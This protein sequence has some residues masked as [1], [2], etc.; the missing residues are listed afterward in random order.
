MS[1]YHA[2]VRA[3]LFVLA[4]LAASAAVTP[5]PNYQAMRQA[6]IAE[7]FVVENIVLHRDAGTLT[8]KSGAIGFTAPVEGRDTVAVFSG[9]AEF[10]LTPV[11]PVEKNYL[12]SLTDQE[13]VKETLDR[14]LFCFTDDTGKEIRSQAK[15]KAEVGKLQE[16]LHDYRKHLRD[17]SNENVEAELVADLY[18]AAR[19]GSFSAWLHGH[20]HSELR[21]TV[22]PRG[23]APSLGPEEVLL[24]NIV[25]HAPDELWYHA[26]LQSEIAAH[27]ESSEEDHRAFAAES[28]KIDTVLAKNDHLA[29]T[30][31][32]RFK[33]L[34]GGERVIPIGLLSTL[35][36]SRV[37][38]DGQ[39]TAFI[40]EDKKEDASFHVVLPKPLEQGS[41][42]E[43][44]IEY[45]GDKVVRK[46]GGG[47]FSV[48]A[49]QSWYPNLNSFHDHAL[50]D[51]TFSV[52][53][54]YTLVS[55]GKLEKEW[56]QKDT[57]CSHWVS[58]VP[59]EV[60]GF[61]YGT[62][63][64]KS[65]T[66]PKVGTIEGYATSETPN[67][68]AGAE[69]EIGAMGHISGTSLMDGTLVD[70]RNALGIFSAFFGKSEFD[71]IAITQQPEFDFG[72]SWPSLVYLPMLAYLDGTQ[73]FRL[74]QALGAGSRENSTI[75]QFV[76]EVTA[77]EVSHQWWGHMVGWAT[78]H[79]QW[80]S[81]G[82]AD[83][84]ASLFLQFT[85]KT[86]DKFLK[87]W[88]HARQNLVERNQY[89]RRTND[90]GPLW[91]GR[92][93]ASEKNAGAYDAVV[94][95]KGGFV[96]H[97][98]RQ[99]M[100]DGQHGDGN[101]Q[102]MMQDF[103][104]EY[105]NRN[106]TTEGFQRVV[107]RHMTPGMNAA[108]DGKMDW[109]FSEW[110]YGTALPK[111]TFDYTVT[112]TDNGKVVLKATLAQSDVPADF[113]MPVP[114]YAEF[115]GNIVRLGQARIKGSTSI[116]IQVELPKKPKRVMINYYHDILEQ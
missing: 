12:K 79:D 11:T 94:Y 32:L 19:P 52:P 114:L 33:A 42:H 116:P 75:N 66:D 91:L 26:H 73:R 30:T 84:S 97:M 29:G 15:T 64:K 28:Y 17:E 27:R 102:A 92:R 63:K 88:E 36:V 41:T 96:L 86:P 2:S 101:F 105:L 83:F 61:N 60:A 45:Q 76:D 95:R 53:K 23:A 35:R 18:R 110:V 43:L 10:T 112:P 103:V 98:L 13:S 80:L 44:V 34:T 109:F 72:Q 100:W 48:G 55:V 77:H 16:I 51:L 68:L 3:A 4:T 115:D 5:D 111:Y 7:S 20:K 38:A 40:Q 49:R 89:G 9:E 71:R 74:M 24:V 78:Y 69:E 107:E 90:A 50:Y 59:L 39:D 37:T 93:L 99:M 58:N 57:A 62:F 14:A 54:S 46:E 87:Y 6:P 65:V 104:R 67:Y 22:D 70:A 1:C 25:A 31:T 56:T 82:F 47:N 113:M 21:F 8:L 85:Q 81:E 106:A 108:G